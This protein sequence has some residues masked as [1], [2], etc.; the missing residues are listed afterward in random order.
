MVQFV[1]TE[2]DALWHCKACHAIGVT[3]SRRPKDHLST[4]GVQHHQMDRPDRFAH[5]AKNAMHLHNYGEFLTGAQNHDGAGS[6]K[7]QLLTAMLPDGKDDLYCKFFRD[8]FFCAREE[9]S[10]TKV[11]QVRGLQY[12]NGGVV[13]QKNSPRLVLEA[14]KAIANVY[15]KAQDERMAKAHDVFGV[16]GD[17][18]MDVALS[19]QEVVGIYILDAVTG[20][21]CMEF[22]DIEDIGMHMH[23]SRDEESPDAQALTATYCATFKRRSDRFASCYNMWTD[24]CPA[25][26]FDGA[27]VMKG[28]KNGVVAILQ[29]MASHIQ[30][31]HAI[32][33]QIEL[34][35]DEAYECSE[36]L[37]GHFDDVTKALVS[38]HAR[39]AK[40]KHRVTALADMVGD[41]FLNVKK[42][43]RTRWQRSLQ[44]VLGSIRQDWRVICMQLHEQGKRKALQSELDPDNRKLSL[45]SPLTAFVGKRF[46][47]E[48]KDSKGKKK[49]EAG[50]IISCD[51]KSE[52]RPTCT[53]KSDKHG[54]LGETEAAVHLMN[55]RL[56][57]KYDS[58]G[59][60]DWLTKGQMI[61]M[62]ELDQPALMRSDK[63]KLYCDA[64]HA[65]YLLFVCTLYD[66]RTLTSELSELSQRG[67]LLPTDVN[68]K[69]ASVKNELLA[70]ARKT[71]PQM[72]PKEQSLLDDYDETSETYQGITVVGW[73][74]FKPTWEKER[75]A[76]I[77]KLAE[78]LE[79]RVPMSDGFHKNLCTI[80]NVKDYPLHDS[81]ALTDH[82]NEALKELFT[83]Y[84]ELF[85]RRS[86]KDKNWPSKNATGGFDPKDMFVK[87][88]VQF[89]QWKERIRIDHD[90][91]K[92]MGLHTRTVKKLWS[93]FI[94]KSE[95]MY[96]VFS[97]FM[98][99]LLSV[100]IDTSCCERWFS[101][102]KRLK[103]KMRNRMNQELLRNLMCICLHGPKDVRDFDAMAAVQEWKTMHTRGIYSEKWFAEMIPMI[104]HIEKAQK[105]NESDEESENE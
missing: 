66:V 103:N 71:K 79:K 23:E 86:E 62:M 26:S 35:A 49:M 45:V 98:R 34:A 40:L 48:F 43:C 75:R 27:S 39:S 36:Y 20:L 83:I 12:S 74:M 96:P 53:N 72:G 44:R 81:K 95:G 6:I 1:H 55:P 68:A 97:F 18:S 101:L 65:K 29:K 28:H 50:T 7:T 61:D 4:K 8:V 57:V 54:E 22:Y 63:Y 14:L 99:L 58:D 77:L 94:K 76:Y 13:Q 70:M 56:K 93:H 52:A 85:R 11:E 41:T 5:H 88:R 104:N 80:L 15:R 59:V 32:A 90:D 87:L 9:L 31:T 47:R 67:T 89:G 69:F 19:E 3:A 91:K 92:T 21:P 17:G 64:S 10:L 82:G 42:Y 73:K 37:S 16:V 105:G 46:K 24:M 84:K 51:L 78:M 102:M 30:F 25:V 60:T 38:A 2:G 100:P 33:H